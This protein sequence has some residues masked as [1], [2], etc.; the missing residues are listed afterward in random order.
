MRTTTWQS[1]AITYPDLVAFAYNPNR[2]VMDT[3]AS[4]V[5]GSFELEIWATD[6]TDTVYTDTRSIIANGS[7]GRVEFALSAYFQAFLGDANTQGAP[8]VYKDVV[9]R[10]QYNSQYQY[11]EFRVLF[12]AMRPGDTF[13]PSRI[14]KWWRNYPQTATFYADN[15][16]DLYVRQ[17]AIAYPLQADE[18]IEAGL[19]T[20]TLADV[21]DTAE[22]YAAFRYVDSGGDSIDQYFE[23]CDC[24]EGVFLRWLDR[25]GMFQYWLFEKGNEVEKTATYGEVLPLIISDGT[26]EYWAGRY[27]GKSA[28]K[29]I[30]AC[31]PLV[32]RDEFEF[33]A[34]LGASAHV[35]VYEDEVW[36][37]V[38]IS[39]ASHTWNRDKAQKLQDFAFTIAYPDTE[40]PKL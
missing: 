38:T 37:P 17:D 19:N 18:Q 9:A 6:D 32:T 12:G 30:T 28:G 14:G 36:V 29:Q 8:T 33:L 5:G 34:D 22:V 40:T 11:F 39:G 16:G 24:A 3:P 4:L 7:A 27:Q 26:R 13:N 25:H 2:I 21:F 10:F 1:I 15:G 23:V 31:A 20:L 35:S